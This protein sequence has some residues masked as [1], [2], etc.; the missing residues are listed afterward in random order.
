MCRQVAGIQHAM[1]MPVI[2]LTR[3]PSVVYYQPYI[4]DDIGCDAENSNDRE[5]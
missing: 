1:A 2:S 4:L 5:G 3:D